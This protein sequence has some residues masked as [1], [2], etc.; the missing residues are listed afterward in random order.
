[1][2]VRRRAASIVL[3]T[4]VFAAPLLAETRT[5]QMTVSVTVIARAVVDVE[6]MPAAIEVT[7]DDVARG[8]V[9]VKEP[10]VIRVR[11]NS[12]SGYMLHADKRDETFSAVE[13]SLPGASMTI[14]SHESWIQR[15]YVRGGDAIP[16]RAVLR[17]APGTTAGVHALPISFSATPL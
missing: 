12:R 16:V 17:L 1:M 2:N 3:A 5:A 14:S 4:A 13:L 15:P 10:M 6:Q 11:T 7:A 9:E 8:Y